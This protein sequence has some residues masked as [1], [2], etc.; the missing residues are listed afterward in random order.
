MRTVMGDWYSTEQTVAA[1]LARAAGEAILEV[2]AAPFAVHYKGPDDPVTDAD[3]RA[4][5]IIVS[6][7]SREFPDDGIVSEERPVSEEARRRTRVWYVD[8]L[9]GTGEFVARTGQFSVIIGLLEQGLPKL[10]V[11][12]RPVDGVLYAGIRD[13]IAWIVKGDERRRTWVSAAAPPHPLRLAVSRSHRSPMIDV[14]KSRLGAVTEVPCG[15]VGAKI[16][17]LLSGQADAYVEPSPCTSKWD[18]CGAEAILRGAGGFMSDMAG[19]P[20]RYE[21][22][23]IKNRLGFVATNRVCHADLLAAI[24]MSE[25]T[26]EHQARKAERR[27][28]E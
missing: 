13:E 28:E 12:Y 14:V 7:L 8:P 17:L 25:L 4:E 21:D 1:D 15:S 19:G 2:Y 27:E 11:I 26:H 24:P 9:D 5:E 20:V 16:G 22:A 23:E 10:G 3:L 6:C 18:V